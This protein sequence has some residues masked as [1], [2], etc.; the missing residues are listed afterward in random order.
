MACVVQEVSGLCGLTPICLHIPVNMTV[1]GVCPQRSHH[2]IRPCSSDCNCSPGVFESYLFT[3]QKKFRPLIRLQNQQ[4]SKLEN[5]LL[6][7]SPAKF[8]FHRLD[9]MCLFFSIH[10][11]GILQIQHVH[12][13]F[14]G[15]S[16]CT[17]F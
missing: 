3:A 6:C 1:Q 5:M 10:K 13:H 12:M 15:Y 11:C 17:H 8:S 9:F 7:K 16:R 14:C 2:R 4:K